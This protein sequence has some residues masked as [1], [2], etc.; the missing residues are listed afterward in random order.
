VSA[1]HYKQKEKNHYV[2]TANSDLRKRRDRKI[3]DHPEFNRRSRGKRQEHNGGGLRSQGGF[4][5]PPAGRSVPENG[6]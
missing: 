2:D 4:N 1:W 6:A 3:N 5:A